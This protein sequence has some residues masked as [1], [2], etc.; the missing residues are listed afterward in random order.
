MTSSG[1]E[2]NKE[3]NDYLTDK[4]EKLNNLITTWRQ[5][6]IQFGGFNH[7]IKIFLEF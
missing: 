1:S 7:L 5:D 4:D 6:F 2:S 3:L